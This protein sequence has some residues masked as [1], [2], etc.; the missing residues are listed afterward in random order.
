MFQEKGSEKIESGK[1]K[2]LFSSFFNKGDEKGPPPKEIKLGISGKQRYDSEKKRWIF[3][4]EECVEEEECLPPPKMFTKSE[5]GSGKRKLYVD[6]LE[7]VVNK[8]NL[9][10]AVEVEE[11]REVFESE[12]YLE[13]ALNENKGDEIQETREFVKN[14]LEIEGFK[15]GLTDF[16]A[17]IEAQIVT[18]SLKPALEGEIETYTIKDL[19]LASEIEHIKQKLSEAELELCKYK[20]KELFMKLKFTQK[21]QNFDKSLQDLN[22]TFLSEQSKT[23]MTLEDLQSTLESKSEKIE[24]LTQNLDD[25]D[26]TISQL[27]NQL[28]KQQEH[29][30]NLES[31]LLELQ[32]SLSQLNEKIRAL[33][34]YNGQLLKKNKGLESEKKNLMQKNSALVKEN[35]NFSEKLERNRVLFQAIQKNFFEYLEKISELEIEN[36]GLEER[37][38]YLSVPEWQESPFLNRDG[39]EKWVKIERKLKQMTR[40][41]GDLQSFVENLLGDYQVSRESYYLD[42]EHEKLKFDGNLNRVLNELSSE[43]V[44]SEQ[45]KQQI[46]LFKHELADKESV[47]KQIH[48]NF[49]EDLEK[50]KEVRRNSK[51][52]IQE[53]THIV[54]MQRGKIEEKN[55]AI[56]NLESVIRDLQFALRESEEE[57]K[58]K[59]KYRRLKE[60]HS[61]LNENVRQVH[62]HNEALKI[63][64]DGTIHQSSEKDLEISNLKEALSQLKT[65]NEVTESALTEKTSFVSSLDSKLLNFNQLFAEKNTEIEEKTQ[66]LAK[67]EFHISELTDTIK[68]SASNLEIKIKENEEILALNQTL[69]SELNEKN[70]EV[71]NLTEKNRELEENYEIEKRNCEKI[72]QTLIEQSDEKE[73]FSVFNSELNKK[74]GEK[75]KEMLENLNQLDEL[76]QKF[77]QMQKDYDEKNDQLLKI[78]QESE[79]YY[80]ILMKQDLEIGELQQKLNKKSEKCKKVKLDNKEKQETL[81]TCQSTIQSL[82]ANLKLS[83]SSISPAEVKKFK[84]TEQSLKQEI[85]NLTEDIENMYSKNLQLSQKLSSF[86]GIDVKLKEKTVEYEHLQQLLV[87]KDEEICK[88]FLRLKEKDEELLLSKEVY[89]QIMNNDPTPEQE[90]LG[91]TE[92]IESEV[93]EN[94]VNEQNGWLASI[95]SAVFLTDSERGEGTK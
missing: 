62:E 88:M 79:K 69:Q 72:R 92:T 94:R 59:E 15:Q 4:G 5:V 77:E 9:P 91:V 58:A 55:E 19:V 71:L 10:V 49:N 78:T 3:E 11:K 81:E 50:I 80:D 90:S 35:E 2:S 13:E 95:L 6:V 66:I 43:K 29:T 30:K 42:L 17:C 1:G 25:S 39:G 16:K 73:N 24:S 40:D 31:T 18:E 70:E 83:E 8:V 51:L 46:I 87:E 14:N 21:T 44:L 82:E 53:L 45:L 68:L 48:Q 23:Q 93:G 7:G 65:Q 38:R 20:S 64:L 26:T 52:K 60:L 34:E 89:Q 41:R 75:E 63:L 61:E 12:V 22:T 84:D 28:S 27:H 47:I 56:K 57:G 76:R 37:I 74:L 86:T 54:R 85:E 36:K 67:L 32:D 33:E